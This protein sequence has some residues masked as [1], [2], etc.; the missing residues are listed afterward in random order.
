[1]KNSVT[2]YSTLTGRICAGC[3]HPI[4]EC[5][6]KQ[7]SDKTVGDGII[8]ISVERKGRKGKTVT[9]LKGFDLT[10]QE[11]HDLA[12]SLKKLCGAGGSANVNEILIQGDH[13]ELLLT[14]LTKQ[15][16]TCKKSGG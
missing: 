8:R 15:G 1:M 4:N 14:Y 6:C 5:I 13:L 16:F 3:N 7:K 10:T 12:S 2:V 9:L 11:L